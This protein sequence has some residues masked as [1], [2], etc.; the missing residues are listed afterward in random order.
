MFEPHF[1]TWVQA[2]PP[3]ESHTAWFASI[4]FWRSG[5]ASERSVI[6]TF[7][8]SRKRNFTGWRA[9]EHAMAH[10]QYRNTQR[11]IIILTQFSYPKHAAVR[12]TH[13]NPAPS[14][15][16][17]RPLSQSCILLHLVSRY[18]ASTKA[19]SHTTQLTSP[20]SFWHNVN[21]LLQLFT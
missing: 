15:T 12:P 13:P 19:A 21:D 14:S 3:H 1:R 4:F 2:L 20:I 6:V 17:D 18:F 11:H 10:N 9:C 7:A 5:I 16:T 8:L